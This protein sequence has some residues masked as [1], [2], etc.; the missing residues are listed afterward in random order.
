MINSH[1]DIS[2]RR[3]VNAPLSLV[4]ELWSKPEH[5]AQW[6]GPRGFKNTIIRHEFKVGAE[7]ELIMHGPDGTDYPNTWV[8]TEIVPHSKIVLDHTVAPKFIATIQ[9]EAE[10]DRTWIQFDMKFA[11]PEV[12]EAVKDF[13]IIGNEQNLERL[14]ALLAQKTGHVLAKPFVITRTF[15]TDVNTMWKMWT[16]PE[17]MAQ[18]WGPKEANVAQFKM[19]FRR[20]GSYLYG[21]KNPDGSVYWGKMSFKDIVPNVRLMFINSFSDEN[22]GIST[23]PMAPDWPQELLTTISFENQ[24]DTQTQVSIEWSPIN[25]TAVQIDCF[26]AAH[27]GMTQGWTGSLDRLTDYLLA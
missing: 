10:G 8:Y 21:L 3:R 12:A 20:G 6:W 11:N 25:A 24:G 14:E 27:D 7:W 13:A 19:D 16:T 23:H 17:H 26:N 18:W 1:S 15:K 9:F 2:N 4:W 22:G 5:I